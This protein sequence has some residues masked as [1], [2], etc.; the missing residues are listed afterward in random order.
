MEWIQ[1]YTTARKPADDS[2]LPLDAP[3]LQGI[4]DALTDKLGSNSRVRVTVSA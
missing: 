2:V 3:F 4:S 1:I